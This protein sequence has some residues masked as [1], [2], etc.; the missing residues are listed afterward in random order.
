MGGKFNHGDKV[1][2]VRLSKNT[3]ERNVEDIENDGFLDLDEGE[4]EN[5][6]IG[7]V[8]IFIEE[9]REEDNAAI[10]SMQLP[11]GVVDNYTI[12]LDELE[13]FSDASNL[14]ALNVCFELQKLNKQQKLRTFNRYETLEEDLILREEEVEVGCQNISKKDAIQ[15][16][17]DILDFYQEH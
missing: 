5:Y 16:A 12:S 8:G 15:I 11:D 14:E 9:D 7:D 13:L 6:Q 17:K 2:V 10:V 3:I 1:Q 4:F